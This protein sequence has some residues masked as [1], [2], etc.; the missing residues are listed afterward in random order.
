[1]LCD[2][3]TEPSFTPFCNFVNLVRTRSQILTII[4][5]YIFNLFSSSERRSLLRLPSSPFASFLHSILDANPSFYPTQMAYLIHLTQ[6]SSFIAFHR[7]RNLH[8]GSLARI[9]NR[10]FVILAADRQGTKARVVASVDILFPS[11]SN[12]CLLTSVAKQSLGMHL[13]R[14]LLHRNYSMEIS[15]PLV[16][17]KDKLHRHP[18]S[19]A[20]NLLLSLILFLDIRSN[21][22]LTQQIN[23]IGLSP[24]EALSLDVRRCS[25]EADKLETVWTLQGSQI[26]TI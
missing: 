25:N 18:S 15:I 22:H 2:S 5:H 26:P 4:P 17:E 14:N 3:L 24:W 21:L 16:N 7:P 19:S 1:M 8:S 13:R 11:Q 12:S 20:A 9:R 23:V 6:I 10:F